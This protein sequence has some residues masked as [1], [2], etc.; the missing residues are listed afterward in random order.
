MYPNWGRLRIP[1]S[2]MSLVEASSTQ[3]V[4]LVPTVNHEKMELSWKLYNFN[5]VMAC[6]DII[7]L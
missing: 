6:I 2:E 4:A 3:P 1:T 7:S 5:E